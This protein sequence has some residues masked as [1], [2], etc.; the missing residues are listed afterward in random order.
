MS[1]DFVVSSVWSSTRS[2][3]EAAGRAMYE[4]RQSRRTTRDQLR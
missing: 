4:D 2:I 3:L 1:L